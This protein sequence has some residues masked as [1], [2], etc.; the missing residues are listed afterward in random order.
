MLTARLPPMML[1]DPGPKNRNNS[2][3]PAIRQHPTVGPMTVSA[4][5]PN[6]PTTST[7]TIL[8]SI[9]NL[10]SLSCALNDEMDP[11]HFIENRE[12]PDQMMVSSF[13]S[14]DVATSELDSIRQKGFL[15]SSHFLKLGRPGRAAEQEEHGHNRCPKI[16][17]SVTNSPA[18]NGEQMLS[19]SSPNDSSSSSFAPSPSLSAA[20]SSSELKSAGGLSFESLNANM[21]GTVRGASGPF[22]LFQKM[23]LKQQMLIYNHIWA[24]APIPANL[25]SSL[26]RGISPS[27]FS[28]SSTGSLR[29]NAAWWGYFHPGHVGSSDPEPGR[30]CRT[31]GKK[32]RCSRDAVPDQKYC[33]RHVNR[34]R[35]RSRKPVESHGGSAKKAA[36]VVASQTPPSSSVSLSFARHQ[37]QNT[38]DVSSSQFWMT[39]GGNAANN[40]QTTSLALDSGNAVVNSLRSSFAT[41]SSFVT[42]LEFYD[43]SV[44][45]T[46]DHFN[47]AWPPSYGRTQLSASFSIPSSDFSSATSSPAPEGK[48]SP[49]H[50]GLGLTEVPNEL[51]SA[52]LKWRAAEWA[53]TTAV[54]AT[55][56][57]PLGEALKS[58]NGTTVD[59]N[60]SFLNLINDGCW[61]LNPRI[62]SSW[63]SNAMQSAAISSLSSSS[64]ND[65]NFEKNGEGLSCLFGPKVVNGHW[66]KKGRLLVEK[67]I[68]S[69]IL[70]LLTVFALGLLMVSF[71]FFYLFCRFIL[72]FW[73]F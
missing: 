11:F 17:R 43:Q 58:K 13:S 66:K 37:I 20:S 54:S 23:E 14:P 47:N 55:M 38:P 68:D 27:L 3:S 33:E 5:Y 2:H 41:N 15:H 32:W 57:G 64:A 31:D 24:N 16:S 60:K 21:K 49:L 48:H 18:S 73:N 10:L 7:S 34:G 72:V 39:A 28:V 70:Y 67:R 12:D 46:V 4:V 26:M 45:Q 65:D 35:H 30:C 51:N 63:T 9:T 36:P 52:Q 61:D 62:E 25:L 71:A 44:K 22:T 6:R 69:K 56:G 50:M 1:T 42:P 19:F 8:T 59:E 40:R 29:H 53:A